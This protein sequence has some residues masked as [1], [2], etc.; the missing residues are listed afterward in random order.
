MWCK[1]VCLTLKVDSEV[2]GTVK[3]KRPHSA[4]TLV[5]E[6]SPYGALICSDPMELKAMIPR[7]RM[8]SPA[9]LFQDKTD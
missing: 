2:L 8:N 4:S 9:A 7:S 5:W 1:G 3:E 6:K